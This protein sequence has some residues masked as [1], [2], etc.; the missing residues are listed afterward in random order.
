MDIPTP[1]E[2]LDTVTQAHQKEIE[3]IVQLI[4]ERIRNEGSCFVLE[5]YYL[6]FNLE[7]DHPRARYFEKHIEEIA[8]HFSDIG[9]YTEVVDPIYYGSHSRRSTNALR[10]YARPPKPKDEVIEV[11]STAEQAAD[12]IMESRGVFGGLFSGNGGKR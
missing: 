6:S 8:S 10:I 1:Q 3:A 7:T 5:P 4:V 9:W 12:M 11:E 2:I